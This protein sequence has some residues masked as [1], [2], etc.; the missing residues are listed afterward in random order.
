VASHQNISLSLTEVSGNQNA[1]TSGGVTEECASNATP[2]AS[3]AKFTISSLGHVTVSC[4]SPT[5]TLLCSVMTATSGFTQS[6]I[7][8]ETFSVELT[9]EAGYTQVPHRNKPAADGPRYK[10]LG[11][12]WAV[13]NVAWIGRRIQEVEAMGQLRAAA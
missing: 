1:K 5:A 11:N 6:G 3:K 12:S 2:D 4:D 9:T 8:P 7:L 13:P 10:S